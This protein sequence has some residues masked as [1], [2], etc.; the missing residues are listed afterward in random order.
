MRNEMEAL[1]RRFKKSR[2]R[3]NFENLIIGNL[4]HN[5]FISTTP[6]KRSY[7]SDFSICLSIVH[8]QRQLKYFRSSSGFEESSPAT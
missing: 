4:S 1:T 5:K 7:L 2:N 3:E 8:A 6:G